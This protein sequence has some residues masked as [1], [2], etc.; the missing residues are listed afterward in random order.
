MLI[1]SMLGFQ[2]KIQKSYLSL[3]AMDL[4]KAISGLGLA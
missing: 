3:A 4:H 1:S 2:I